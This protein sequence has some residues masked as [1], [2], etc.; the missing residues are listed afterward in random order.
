MRI[1]K[2]NNKKKIQV[3]PEEDFKRDSDESQQEYQ[4]Y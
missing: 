3:K 1:L 4:K 2:N